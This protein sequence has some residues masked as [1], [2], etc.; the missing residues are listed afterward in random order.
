MKSP[1]GAERVLHWELRDQAATRS[2]R[3]FFQLISAHCGLKVLKGP[4]APAR[5]DSLTA[6]RRS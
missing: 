2:Q 4:S 6:W 3:T 1:H 5:V